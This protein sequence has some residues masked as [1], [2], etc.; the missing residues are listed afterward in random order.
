MEDASRCNSVFAM[1]RLFITI[2]TKRASI[3][4]HNEEASVVDWVCSV[5]DRSLGTKLRHS[6]H[7]HFSAISSLL[8]VVCKHTKRLM[9]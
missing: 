1:A 2:I 5:A 7:A 8:S 6:C 3:C 4:V 9:T